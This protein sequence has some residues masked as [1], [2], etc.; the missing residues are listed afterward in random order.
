MGSFSHDS[1]RA[2]STSVFEHFSDYILRLF[3]GRSKKLSYDFFALYIS[4]KHKFR[5]AKN[6]D[7]K[8]KCKIAAS[9]IGI[10]HYLAS[11]LT[12]VP[13]RSKNN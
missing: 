13:E 3:N 2:Q 8:S 4:R 10:V 11:N 9:S 5:T 1:L 7:K 12:L 6:H